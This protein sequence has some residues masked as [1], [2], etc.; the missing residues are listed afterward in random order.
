MLDRQ[1]GQSK[2]ITEQPQTIRI[3]VLAVILRDFREK[4]SIGPFNWVVPVA[5]E[6]PKVDLSR[7]PG[8][9]L[10][11]YLKYLQAEERN[12][13][14]IQHKDQLQVLQF[15]VGAQCDLKFNKISVNV[16]PFYLRKKFRISLKTPF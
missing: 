11:K 6:S 13:V 1:F 5:S 15:P 3:S 7:S 12:K 16:R 14:F 4:W 10:E 2:S 8:T 9:N